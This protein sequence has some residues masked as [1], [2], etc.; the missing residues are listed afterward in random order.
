M[1]EAKIKEE[2]ERRARE[3]EKKLARRIQEYPY[4]WHRHA[5]MEDVRKEY[6]ELTNNPIYEQAIIKYNKGDGN[7]RTK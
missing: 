5:D 6:L 3:L 7:G 2:E 1:I 4:T